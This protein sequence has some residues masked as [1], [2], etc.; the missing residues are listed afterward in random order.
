MTMKTLINYNIRD[1]GLFNNRLYLKNDERG[2]RVYT[3]W[4]RR[5]LAAIFG[6]AKVQG[7]GETLYLSATDL[8]K[9]YQ[10]HT[11]TFPYDI[12]TRAHTSEL[13]NLSSDRLIDLI[14]HV[15]KSALL[16][17]VLAGHP[18]SSS[19]T[20]Q[21]LDLYGITMKKESQNFAGVLPILENAA[22]PQFI[23]E[24]QIVLPIEKLNR[25]AREL[26]TEAKSFKETEERKAAHIRELAFF[27]LRYY[28]QEEVFPT[29]NVPSPQ[30]IDVMILQLQ[31]HAHPSHPLRPR[32]VL[33]MLRGLFD[34]DG[35]HRTLDQA[36]EKLKEEFIV[37]KDVNKYIL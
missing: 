37:S 9:W 29:N 31:S 23:I 17:P 15:W 13:K 30:M 34:L 36:L 27:L 3:G 10:T 5:I 11:G 28:S 32:Y 2:I 12:S 19:R 14:D 35:K 24:G 21:A 22:P 1:S 20:I 26:I 25:G 4:A 16:F 7:D 6:A 8:C 33:E 18:Q